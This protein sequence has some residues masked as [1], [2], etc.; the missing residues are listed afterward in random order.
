MA[1]PATPSTRRRDIHVRSTPPARQRLA[2]VFSDR[3]GEGNRP[4]TAEVR[5][6]TAGP[7]RRPRGRS[8][9]FR[10]LATAIVRVGARIANLRPCYTRPPGGVAKGQ[11]YNFR[12]DS[13]TVRRSGMASQ[14]GPIRVV[15]FGLGPIGAGVVR[16]V[17]ARK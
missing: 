3:D 13:F 9:P 7:L 6:T 1:A 17:A 14:K 2:N 12:L 10:P 16:Q 11:R 8:G 4:G 15:H 5:S